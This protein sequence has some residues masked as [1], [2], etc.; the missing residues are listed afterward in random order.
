MQR[1]SQQPSQREEVLPGS[2]VTHF[3]VL[4]QGQI[5]KQMQISGL[6]L[7]VGC[8]NADLYNGKAFEKVFAEIYKIGSGSHNEEGCLNKINRI[9]SKNKRASIVFKISDLG[10]PYEN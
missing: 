10:V 9:N 5:L 1:C 8:I 3:D 4:K 7:G 6:V 2:A